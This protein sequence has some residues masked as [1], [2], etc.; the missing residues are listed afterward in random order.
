[1]KHVFASLLLLS[2]CTTMVEPEVE[3]VNRPPP[4]GDPTC[5]AWGCGTN[6][7]TLGDGLV[8]DEIDSTGMDAN[9]GGLRLVGAKSPSGDPIWLH[10]EGQ[11]LVGTL[12]SDP[13]VRYEMDQLVGTVFTLNHEVKGDYEVMITAVNENDLHFWAEP[14]KA[15]P[16]YEM[17]S[18][19]AGIGKFDDFACKAKLKTDPDWSAAA[20]SA[21]VFNGDK[22]DLD[23]LTVH[24]TGPDDRWFNIACAATVPAKLHLT[25][26]TNAS[27]WEQGGDFSTDR[28]ER[29]AMLKMFMADFC[30]D[31]VSMTVDGVPL[32]YEDQYHW[33]PAT[34]WTWVEALWDEN[35]AI[36]MSHTR[37][38][39]TVQTVRK[40]CAR[41]I[42]TCSDTANWESW[43]H[44]LSA[45]H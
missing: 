44:V 16:F 23:D 6:S 17:K 11:N 41:E 4:G 21:I 10:A 19:K 12:L 2:A 45:V 28:R 14:K 31:G 38:S 8:F 39:T 5:P 15:V 18:R 24:D 29:T 36:C 26:H 32:K 34:S 3:N 43:A 1:M 13:S 25:R 37:P 22:Y 27:S 42:P 40:N 9:R 30:G 20:H 33:L 7:A 35:G